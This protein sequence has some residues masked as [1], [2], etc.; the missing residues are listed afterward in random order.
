VRV[1]TTGVFGSPHR[2][3]VGLWLLLH[4]ATAAAYIDPGT[5]SALFYVV[6]GL[7][8]SIYFGIRGLYY[9][10]VEAV[11]RVR[12]KDQR[13]DLAIHCE[14]PRYEI[15]FLP[16]LKALVERGVEPTFFT[17][18]E[19]NASFEP[20]PAKVTHRSIAPGTMGYAYLNNIEADLLVTTTPQLDVM[21]F[22]R[23]RRV[24]HY[25]N[26]SHGLG[27]S[28]YVRPYAYDY[29]D[30]VLCCGEILKANI[31][32]IEAIR[33]LPAKQLY[34]TGIPH[35]EE[36]LRGRGEAAPPS[37][38]PVVLV[39][40]SWGPFSMFESFGIDFIA[41]I[42]QQYRVIVRPHPHM[43]VSQ[44][45]LYAKVLAL[46]GVTVDTQRTPA[47][48]MS[49]AHVL[50]SD[51]SG[52]THEFAFIHERPVLI[53]DHRIAGGFE[54]DLLGG[55]SELKDR[56]REFI[57]PIPPAEIPNIVAHIGRTLENHSVERLADV[58]AQLVYNFGKASEVAAGQLAEILAREQSA[59]QL[60]T[61]PADPAET[62]AGLRAQ[63][64]S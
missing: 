60:D 27:E 41:A 29:F 19:R 36:L 34:E 48:A 35:Y 2:L 61:L 47:D 39:A 23:S 44:P 56:C 13:C 33:G 24:K 46:S 5:G 17:M 49:Q 51:I 1:F 53:I 25:A 32:R 20:L 26:L 10:L 38:A 28:R 8:V 15:T 52:I 31:R 45:E 11:F 40:P 7:V 54:G 18:Y 30:S 3:L 21:T 9:R 6:S 50:L 37:G 63:G 16:V 42:A 64:A 58:R 55:D 22:R 43:K 59:S 4:A 14:D 12:H 62:R 57:V